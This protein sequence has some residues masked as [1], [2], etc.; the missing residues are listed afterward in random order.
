MFVKSITSSG[1]VFTGTSL[2]YAVVLV[3]GSDN[4]S[5]IIYDNSSAAGT[6][7]I[8]LKTLANDS[9]TVEFKK[10][11]KFNTGLYGTLAGTGAKLYVYFE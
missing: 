6:V 9:K 2:V 4:S 10:S 11:V 1:S 5:V 8:E 7:K 3:G